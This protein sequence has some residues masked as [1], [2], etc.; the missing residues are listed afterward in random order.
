MPP[1]PDSVI[2][3]GLMHH[4][5]LQA[6]NLRMRSAIAAVSSSGPRPRIVRRMQSWVGSVLIQMGTALQVESREPGAPR[7]AGDRLLPLAITDVP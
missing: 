5:E 4:Q 1:H 2:A 6:E 7:S 3:F